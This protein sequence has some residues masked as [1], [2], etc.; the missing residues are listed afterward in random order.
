MKFIFYTYFLFVSISALSA[1]PITTRKLLLR[2]SS[3]VGEYR[4]TWDNMIE[5]KTDGTFFRGWQAD[6]CVPE[7]HDLYIGHKGKWKVI[8]DKVVFGTGE[9][10]DDQYYPV[11][12]GQ[13]RYLI[14]ADGIIDFINDINLGIEPKSKVDL[15]LVRYIR[16]FD[17]EKL[18]YG[19][20]ILP[21]AYSHMLLKRPVFGRIVSR[22][23]LKLTATIDVGKADGIYVGMKLYSNYGFVAVTKVQDKQSIVKIFNTRYHSKRCQVSHISK[24]KWISTVHSSY[25]PNLKLFIKGDTKAL[26]RF[27]VP[28]ELADLTKNKT[29]K[30]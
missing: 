12:W 24:L 13:R 15:D 14:E 10:D 25:R 19:D 4:S 29:P 28:K 8:G 1:A 23:L 20:P 30:R 22:S 7:D 21:R 27:T 18:V 5:L 26:S 11:K 9:T 3:L 6:L 17:E 16:L 2:P